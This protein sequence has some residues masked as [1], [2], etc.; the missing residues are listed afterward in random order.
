[1][2][3]GGEILFISLSLPFITI[4]ILRI[5]EEEVNK[6]EKK[7]LKIALGKI[8]PKCTSQAYLSYH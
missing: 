6:S 2:G 4:W 7:C 5:D 8:M 3:E 1:M